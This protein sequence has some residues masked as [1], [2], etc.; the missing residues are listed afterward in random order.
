MKLEMKKLEGTMRIM[1][2]P[3]G[4]MRICCDEVCANCEWRSDFPNAP[5]G[6]VYYCY[7]PRTTLKAVTNN[8]TC[9]DFQGKK[10]RIWFVNLTE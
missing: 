8:D 5:E 1:K 7:A 4:A 6:E 3:E 9:E 10:Q 2:K